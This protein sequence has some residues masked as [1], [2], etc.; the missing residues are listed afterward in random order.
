MVDGAVRGNPGEQL[1]EGLDLR[2]TEPVALGGVLARGGEDLGLPGVEQLLD[3]RA[4][5]RG[6]LA[7]RGE[8]GDVRDR[9]GARTA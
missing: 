4:L 9:P 3:L 1:G 6:Q 5:G 2:L 7:A 8:G